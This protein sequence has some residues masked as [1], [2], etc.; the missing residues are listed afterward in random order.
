MSEKTKTILL[1]DDNKT[2]I[3]YAGLL[4]KR[5]GYDVVPTAGAIEALKIIKTIGPD[6]IICD[7][8]MP[9]MDG[10]T[11]LRQLRSDSDLN[12]TPIIMASTDS[13]A[14]TAEECRRLGSNGFL[15]KPITPQSLHSVLQE[16]LSADGGEKR[17]HPRVSFSSKVSIKSPQET[18]DLYA[19]NLSRGGIYI[20]KRDPLPTGTEVAVCIGQGE[21]HPLQL[22]GRV[23][24]KKEIFRGA[25]Q[26]IPGMAI[27][28]QGLAESE[29]SALED[30]IN[31]LLAQDILEEQEEVVVTIN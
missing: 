23:I 13:G 7:V 3:M 27:K 29:A 25:F 20:R 17:R 31:R 18:R 12:E 1:I 10:P 26:S 9:Q 22:K 11:L 14:Q 16:C 5:M 30:F 15:L 21:K 28:F 2:F 4:L 24:Y 6:G 8:N 19:V